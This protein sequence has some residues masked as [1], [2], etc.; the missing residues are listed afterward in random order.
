[1]STER[2]KQLAAEAAALLVM[3]GMNVGLGTGT[4][5]AYLLPALARR[6]LSIRCFAT[7]ERT[8]QAAAT[9]GLDGLGR[10]GDDDEP[11]RGPRDDLLPGVRAA[12]ALHQPAVRGDLV[13]AV[14]GDVETVDAR[15][16]LDPQAQFPCG[17]LGAR[18]RGR[19]EYAERPAG[20]GGEQV[21]HRRAGAEPDGHPVLDQ[22]RG[23][24]R[25]DLLLPLDASRIVRLACHRVLRSPHGRP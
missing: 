1:M 12:A 18:R 3:D 2:E 21:R 17:L 13:R 14:D 20:Q 4:T 19:A 24:L 25:G 5:A 7:S 9:L 6:N 10:V 8:A 22:F 16:V 23:R 11:V 15:D